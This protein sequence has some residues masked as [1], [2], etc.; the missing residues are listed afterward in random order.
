MED[1][2]NSY[3][4]DSFAQRQYRNVFRIYNTREGLEA[5]RGPGSGS[6][7]APAPQNRATDSFGPQVESVLATPAEYA[8]GCRMQ[9]LLS[10]GMCVR[11][12]RTT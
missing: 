6:S 4:F 11:A 2:I 12:V 5:A 1:M 10:S 9:V 3:P 8:D 7:R